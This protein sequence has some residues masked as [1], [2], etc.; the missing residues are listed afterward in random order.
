M[1]LKFSI[2]LLLRL[3]QDYNDLPTNNSNNIFFLD[4]VNI[5]MAVQHSERIFLYR[6]KL[7]YPYLSLGLPAYGWLSVDFN[8]SFNPFN[9]SAAPLKLGWFWSNK[10]IIIERILF[11]HPKLS[12]SITKYFH[13]RE[14]QQWKILL[15]HCWFPNRFSLMA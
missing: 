12:A 1:V 8:I 3:T 4:A 7:E 15:K 13:L 6:R 5:E 9:H 14:C 10:K 2:H 11:I